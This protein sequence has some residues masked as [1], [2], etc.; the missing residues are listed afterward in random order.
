LVGNVSQVT[1]APDWLRY[2]LSTNLL[3]RGA[4]GLAG[5][6]R[7]DTDRGARQAD[8]ERRGWG[9]STFTVTVLGASPA[10][11]NPGGACSGYLL[12]SGGDHVLVECG[13]GILGRL[14]E[15]V[16]LNRLLGVVI[17]HLHADHF[18]DL[19]PLRYGLKY[20]R[21]RE[22]PGLPLYGPPGATEFLAT[23]GRALDGDVHF[24]D[25]T[26]R[27]HEFEPGTPLQVGPFR[28]EFQRVKHF[29][30][31]FAM[32]VRA[33]RKLVYSG[34]AAPCPALVEHARDADLFLCEAANDSLQDDDPN[35][36]NRGHMTA[37]EA[38]DLAAKSGARRL[39]LTHYRSMSPRE[40]ALSE[41]RSIFGD[42]V[43]YVE[44]GRRYVV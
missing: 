31:S 28:F 24:F 19:V 44:E 41:A 25:A 35:P 34:D 14:R 43:E 21:L 30:P 18:M 12:S 10:W 42:S 26:Y 22:E 27:L 4:G 2:I 13:F 39:L 37:A 33:G 9:L 20:G 8:R 7:W 17:S 5:E 6:P 40:A 1:A 29:V 38:A 16:D 23:L 32:A 15:R 36:K 11:T 3:A